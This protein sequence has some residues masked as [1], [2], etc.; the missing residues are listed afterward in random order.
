MDRT[1]PKL[2][3]SARLLCAA[4][5]ALRE[6]PT[7]IRR[8]LG[9]HELRE[10]DVR[11]PELRLPARV[12][13]DAYARAATLT[14]NAGFGLLAGA[15]ARPSDL[16]LIHYL[17]LSSQSLRQVVTLGARY[18][19]LL[20][21][22]AGLIAL[23]EGGADAHV[24]FA[25]A[26]APPVVMDALA[27][28]LARTIGARLDLDVP[29]AAGA[30][31]RL[32]LKALHIAH[33]RPAYAAQYEKLFGVEPV[34]RTD[35][36]AFV[37]PHEALDAPLLHADAEVREQ[38]EQKATELLRNRTA[39]R[40]WTARVYRVVRQ[41]VHEGQP[42]VRTSPGSSAPAA[43]RSNRRLAQEQTTFADILG[44]VRVDLGTPTCARRPCRSPRSATPWASRRSPHST[45]PSSVGRPRIPATTASATR[46]ARASLRASDSGAPCSLNESA[47]AVAGPGCAR[48]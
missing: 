23:D 8:V 47:E 9:E 26:G 1:R 20:S 19:A 15:H 24:R 31:K 35:H 42:T 11:N 30:R 46:P 32:P 28:G 34:F 29:S 3:V 16:G 44:R 18:A 33:A 36:Y 22:R 43:P 6:S 40:T 14:N 12:C 21:R 5:R 48:G 27:V 37:L 41:A 39:H 2:S 4:L 17:A 10:A 13:Y 45:A 38:L 25:A 7:H